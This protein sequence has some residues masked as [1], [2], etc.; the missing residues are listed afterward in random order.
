MNKWI[1]KIYLIFEKFLIGLAIILLIALFIF[2]LV[3]LTDDYNPQPEVDP[4]EI[5]LKEME[6]AGI[7]PNGYW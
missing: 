4:Y 2:C 3:C 6:E 5:Y 7:P 1:L